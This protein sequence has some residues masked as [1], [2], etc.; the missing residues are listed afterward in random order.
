MTIRIRYLGGLVVGLVLGVMLPLAGGDT[1]RLLV[2]LTGLVV[3][4]A[5][6]LIFP[7]FF[8]GMI[9]A[10]DELRSDRQLVAVVGHGALWTALAVV[11][12]TL[13]GVLGVAVLSPERIPPMIQE[14]QAVVPPSVL[15]A[16]V[17]GLPNNLFQVFVIHESAAGGILLV[18]FLIGMSL[19]YDRNITSPV[20]L[21]ADSLN[22]IL[23]RLNNLLVN[24]LGVLLII[25]TAASVVLLREVVNLTIFL[26]LLLV[27]VVAVALVGFVLFPLTIFLVNRD[28]KETVQWIKSMLAPIVMALVTGDSYAALGTLAR[29]SKEDMNVH[30][31]IGA[32][33]LP[34]VSIYGRG[35]SALV[36]IAGTLL[37]IR[38]Y[39]ALEIGVGPM[40]GLALAAMAFSFLL[41]RAPGNGVMLILSYLALLYGRGLEESYLILLPVMPLLERLGAVLDVMTAG[42]VTQMIQVYTAGK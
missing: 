31:R 18:A 3:T 30:R 20:S 27:I 8:T 25:P 4:V 37:V 2:D 16:I 29:S 6:F 13:V 33:A 14:G 10:V 34:I 36:G 1:G 15:G 11:V 32:A 35:G 17:E 40:V 24:W 12:S 23:Y 41:A 42:F 26:Q 5:R 38:S 28:R 39:T 22:R 21:V 7:L 19:Q 9:I